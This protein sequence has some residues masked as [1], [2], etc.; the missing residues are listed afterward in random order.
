[1]ELPMIG[2]KMSLEDFRRIMRKRQDRA[3]RLRFTPRVVPPSDAPSDSAGNGQRQA[4]AD[5]FY[6][7]WS[8]S[9]GK[10]ASHP[11]PSGQLHSS[12]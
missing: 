4:A 11:A 3:E 9:G 6:E 10:S 2:G 12:G 7:R 5:M 1:M 8:K